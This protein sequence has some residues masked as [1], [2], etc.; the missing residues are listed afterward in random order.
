MYYA[1][2][3]VQE[4]MATEKETS[5]FI[6]KYFSYKFAKYLNGSEEPTPEK[7]Q[8]IGHA[9]DL[10]RDLQT[11]G[12]DW[13]QHYR[14]NGKNGIFYYDN[15]AQ[16]NHINASLP[17]FCTEIIGNSELD[18]DARWGW[19]VKPG[20]LTTHYL[21]CYIN[22]AKEDGS[23]PTPYNLKCQ[24]IKQ[25]Y[26]IVIRKERLWDYFESVGYPKEIIM[27]IADGINSEYKK[28]G[29]IPRE[30]IGVIDKYDRLMRKYGFWMTKSKAS[31]FKESA[32]NL[33]TSIRKLE[34]LSDS[35]FIVTREEIR[36]VERHPHEFFP[37]IHQ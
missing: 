1:R 7:I 36:L 25:M 9:Q 24:D 33:V 4:D 5:E 3:T 28:R 32:V 22:G 37:R 27:D 29:P 21:L 34:D 2:R 10:G 23:T 18:G 35:Q 15:K 17:S 30:T 26:I 14:L 13:H 16:T 8:I 12:V 20:L 11:K 6:D 19:G 31:Q